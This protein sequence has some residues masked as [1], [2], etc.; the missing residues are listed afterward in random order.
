MVQGTA[1]K[2]AA[3]FDGWAEHLRTLGAESVAAGD[4]ARLVEIAASG[5]REQ[6]LR[7][8]ALP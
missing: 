5:I 7:L 2:I 3:A 4:Q 6:Q 1:G 8:L